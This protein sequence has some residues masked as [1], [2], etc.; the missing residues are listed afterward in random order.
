MY[1]TYTLLK[2]KIDYNRNET[3]DYLNVFPS[4]PK[5]H[6]NGMSKEPFEKA[7]TDIWKS[8]HDQADSN[9]YLRFCSQMY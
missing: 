3:R 8:R 7:I 2:P 5:Q 6:L 1:K 4:P 9:F